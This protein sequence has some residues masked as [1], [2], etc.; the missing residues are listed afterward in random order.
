MFGQNVISLYTAPRRVYNAKEN[1]L[2]QRKSGLVNDLPAKPALAWRL[3]AA[4]K[5]CKKSQEISPLWL[6]EPAAGFAGKITV[7]GKNGN[8]GVRRR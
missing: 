1:Q 5:S 8:T 6:E 2:K 3:F 7:V 4:V